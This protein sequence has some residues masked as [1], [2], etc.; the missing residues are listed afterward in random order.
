MKGKLFVF[1]CSFSSKHLDITE[2]DVYGYLLAQ[3]LGME[4][5]NYSKSGLSNEMS[6]LYLTNIMNEVTKDDIIIFQFTSYDRRA[7]LRD[8]SNIEDFHTSAGLSDEN[9]EDKLKQFNGEYEIFTREMIVDLLSFHVNWQRRTSKVLDITIKN[10]LNRIKG[11]GVK[12]YTLYMTNQDF[13]ITQPM[14]GSIKFPIDGDEENLSLNLFNIDKGC[15]VSNNDSHPNKGGHF[16]YKE[17]IKR[18]ILND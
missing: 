6:L 15:V 8:E 4:L 7:Y 17:F 10:V 12:V 11:L 13:D 1:G 14:E 5:H 18:A 9:I 2:T 3:E 16:I